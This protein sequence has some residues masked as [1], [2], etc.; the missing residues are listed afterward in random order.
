MIMEL[1][2]TKDLD[3]ATYAMFCGDNVDKLRLTK[4]RLYQ[5]H[6]QQT[7]G[8]GE[9]SYVINDIGNRSFSCWIA[10]DHRYYM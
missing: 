3:K 7:L 5:V 9:E 10:V 6:R 8:V 4:D 1:Q 2:E